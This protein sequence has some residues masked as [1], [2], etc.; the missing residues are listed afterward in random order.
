MGGGE[1]VGHL[2]PSVMRDEGEKKK[3]EGI[4][5]GGAKHVY[6]KISNP[7]TALEICSI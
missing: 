1:N 5:E 6:E 2:K 3:T 4:S 7:K